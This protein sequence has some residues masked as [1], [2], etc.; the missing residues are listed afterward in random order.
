MLTA[1]RAAAITSP[2]TRSPR[3]A[4]DRPV[5]HAQRHR[6]CRAATRARRAGAL[7]ADFDREA[8]AHGL[9]TPLGINSTTG[10][11]GLTLGGGFGWLTRT[12]RPDRR[13]PALCDR[14]HRR[15]RAARRVGD[16][17]ARAVL[18]AA[19]R[20]RQLRRRHV[21]RVPAPSRRPG[22]LAGLVVYPHAQAS[23]CCAPGAT[24]PLSARR[25]QRLGGAAQGAAAAVPARVGARHRRRHLAAAATAATS[26]PGER[27]AAPLRASASRWASSSGRRR[28]PASS[29]PSIRCSRPARATTGSR[30]TSA[31]LDDAALDLAIDAAARAAAVR[32]ARSSCAARRRDGAGR[33]RRRRPSSHRDTQYM[34]NVHGRWSRPGRGRARARLGAQGLRWTWRRTPAGSGYV[35][36]LTEDEGERVASSYGSNHARL[37]SVK[38]RYDPSNLFRM[39]LNIA[40]AD[41]APRRSP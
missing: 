3:R 5:G 16:A 41:T 21:V 29:P 9:A 23:R 31:A 25:A 35:N 17:R 1:C 11:A 6:R 14:G 19:R 15:R 36:F 32:S 7:L 30:T 24:S 28:T 13:Q 33:C 39:N 37:Q 38:R 34:M 10:V 27:A 40:P 2:A 8:Q 20:R 22:G 12:P 26:R 18:G 4:D